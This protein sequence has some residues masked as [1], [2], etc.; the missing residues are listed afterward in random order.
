MPYHMGTG[1]RLESSP[2][3]LEKT[4]TK[5]MAPDFQGE[6]TIHCNAAPQPLENVFLSK[7]FS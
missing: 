1:P 3:K 6:R 7:P 2:D 4:G 5:H